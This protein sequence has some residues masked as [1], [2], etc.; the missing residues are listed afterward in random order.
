MAS[1]ERRTEPPASPQAAA[2]TA[3]TRRN[4]MKAG[5][6]EKEEA[7]EKERGQL[8]SA[9]LSGPKAEPA[10][11]SPPRHAC[12]HR[13]CR[14]AARENMARME[15][16]SG[17]N[18]RP[19]RAL[20]TL[21]VPSMMLSLRSD[22]IKLGTLS[23]ERFSKDIIVG[24][25][26]KMSMDNRGPVTEADI[27]AFAQY[28]RNF[29]SGQLLQLSEYF[30]P[31]FIYVIENDIPTV[32]QE[33]I[34]R[35]VVT[36]SQAQT[37]A[38]LE[39]HRDATIAAETLVNEVL[40]ESQDAAVGLW[41]CF[42]ALRSRWSHPNLQGMVEEI[43][44]N[45]N[46]LLEEILLNES[47][48]NLD[49]EVKACQD[50][51]KNI[52]RKQTKMLKECGSQAQSEGQSFPIL[53]RYVEI[54]IVSDVHFR[55]QSA[56]EYEALAAAGELNEYRLRHKT[57]AELERITPDRL[58]RWCFRSGRSPRSVMVSGVAGVGKTTLVQKFVFDWATG[59]HYQKFAFVFLFKFRDL[60]ALG[61]TTSLEQL[62]QQ[63]YPQLSDHL[64][65]ILQDT[66]KL[67]FIFDGLDESNC[68]LDLSRNRSQD[69]CDQVGDVK[70]VCVIVA[71]LLKQTLLKG[72][73]VLLTSRPNKLVHLETGVLHR[74]ASIVGFLSQERE[75]YFRNFFED[76]VVT[77]KALSYV[78]DSQVLYTLCYNPSYCWITCTA[79]QPCFTS[80]TGQLQPLPKTM[81]QLFV[82][83]MKHMLANHSK[84]LPGPPEV[85]EM[86][87]KLGWLADYGL[88]NHTL[89]FDQN[90]LEAFNL[91][92]SPFLTA[93]LVENIQAGI[94]VSSVTYSFVHLT[95]QEFFAALVHYLD[96][97]EQ[98][99]E[100]VM[101]SAKSNRGGEY[102][103]FSRFLCGLSHPAT[104]APLEENLGKFSTVTTKRVIE[105]LAKMDWKTL[106]SMD[107]GGR[108]NGTE[109]K[110]KAMNIFH[111]LF[112]A[113]NTQLVRQA[114][115]ET[116]Y[117]DF[118]ELFLM[119]VDCIILAYVFSCCRQIAGL[120]L[121]S[122]LIQVE[123]LQRLGP[124]LHKI[125]ELSLQ[126]NDLK[127]AAVKDLVCA[128]THPDCKLESLSLAKNAFTEPCCEDL[129]SA[130]SVN[131]TL[132]KLDLSK[133]KLQDGG[134]SSLLKAF[135]DPRCK[136]RELV[137]QEN[138]LSDASCKTLCSA[139]AR[140]TSLQLLNL[141]GNYF[142][143]RCHEEMCDLILHSP[144]LKEIR[145]SLNQ[146]SS[147][148]EGYLKQLES[149]REGLKIDF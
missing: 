67:L 66:K 68:D 18:S 120:N 121:D 37:Y 132:L 30:R 99:F 59:R 17:W 52:L 122:C 49:L 8:G 106:I 57:Q 125:R 65:M 110:R 102:E 75:R 78:R 56:E 81:A 14:G 47:G 116:S 69:L 64:P 74:V 15:L 6:G 39:K 24:G 12:V 103:I 141:N 97:K 92:R 139:L 96:F 35:R 145:L 58:F 21:D 22:I 109:K 1:K 29:T 83:Y 61:P 126:N 38:E 129:G 134:L 112:E 82:S 135:S 73:S 3:T 16:A 127:D 50:E 91:D 124:Q 42:F 20:L 4:A 140:N 25:L 90:Y 27:E 148:A 142:T 28:L 93:F 108:K 113:H 130:L 143:D 11:S 44:R 128:L 146:F 13:V 136:I 114:V 7:R 144:V 53:S 26:S 9:A 131:Q 34:S 111:L 77:H 63:A 54:K 60:N 5:E 48:C 32:L 10:A 43:L 40:A 51:H 149:V 117:M 72:C 119:P 41:K 31:E 80:K 70:P 101:V 2:V 107:T 133:N 55:K 71:S 36:Y 100:D 138:S 118:S 147:E 95:V 84:Q 137:I 19:R 89:V 85:R 88:N 33:L 123:G 94:S 79:L 23:G 45:G 86:L 46:A 62:I 104:R 115:E 87:I 105:W 98:N 76:D